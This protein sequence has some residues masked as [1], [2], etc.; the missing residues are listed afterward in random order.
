MKFL[1]LTGLLLAAAP[2]AAQSSQPSFEGTVVYRN[3]VE[4]T[5]P[6]R[7]AQYNKR[8]L[9]LGTEETTVLQ[10]PNAS[11]TTN[12][13]TVNRRVYRLG[14]RRLYL[15]FA[16]R[17]QVMWYDLS[18][19]APKLKQRQV[20]PAADTV[21]GQICDVVELQTD[22]QRIRVSLHPRYRAA[23]AATPALPDST[24]YR[25]LTYPSAS[26]LVLRRV[27]RD[28]NGDVTTLVATALQPGPVSNAAA[29][30][31]GSTPD[32]ELVPN[33]YMLDKQLNNNEMARFGRYMSQNIKYPKAAM[34]AGVEG[35]VVLEFLV[36]EDSRISDIQVLR[37]VEPT[38][39]AEAVR[40]LQQFARWEPRTFRGKPVKSIFSVPVTYR[41][42]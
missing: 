10:G 35:T 2:L 23:L 34:R 39:D 26:S 8:D 19:D 4:Y 16:N 18:H 17:R 9:I 11:V 40:V 7:K 30:L 29:T 38:L 15:H 36:N 41:L 12:G 22:K 21:L 1:F 28:E 6:V 27:T 3:T 5:D 37:A 20:L 31:A 25:A 24:L 32:A 13:L 14:E 33:W 42:E